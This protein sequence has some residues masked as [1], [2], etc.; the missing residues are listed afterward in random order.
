MRWAAVGA[1]VAAAG[2]VT[3]AVLNR[4]HPPTPGT[5][6][7]SNDGRGM[8]GATTFTFSSAGAS[9][10]DGDTLRYAWQFG[11]GATADES[12]VT[13]VYREPGTFTVT[14][15]VS[16][17]GT[18]V[19]APSLMV[20]VERNLAGRW[21]GGHALPMMNPLRL[22][23]VHDARGLSGT[24]TAE[25][26]R[27]TPGGTST[28]QGSIDPQSYPCRVSWSTVLLGVITVRFEGSVASAESGVMTGTITVSEPGEFS[29][30]GTTTFRR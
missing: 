19:F 18:P 14:L 12:E 1:G 7:A 20:T 15:S 5:I 28:L 10:P 21:S 26:Y 2:A 16:D 17:G 8:A 4:N 29:G 27:G 24:L 23:L 3:Y 9:D 6:A 22:D 30:S 13:H 11:D 25:P